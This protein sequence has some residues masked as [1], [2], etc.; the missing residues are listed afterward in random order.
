MSFSSI[1]YVND[2]LDEFIVNPIPTGV[3]HFWPQPSK[4]AWHFH[5]FEARITKIHDFV[6]FSM[7]LV[8]VKL[9]LQKKFEIL[10]N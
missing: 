3:G 5:S 6:Y 4:T 9:I 8:P 2:E 7:C 10:K 1:A